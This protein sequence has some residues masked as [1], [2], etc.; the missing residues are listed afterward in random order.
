MGF[1]NNFNQSVQP[2]GT[3]DKSV[4]EQKQKEWGEKLKN[5]GRAVDGLGLEMDE[6]IKEAVVALVSNGLDTVGSCGGHIVE[7]EKTIRLPWVQIAY[8]N[9]PAYRF[10]GEKEIR[11]EIMRKYDLKSERD[12]FLSETEAGKKYYSKTSDCENSPEWE[13]WSQ[14]NEKLRENIS[15]LLDE[16]YK[17]RDSK[18]RLITGRAYPVW[19]ISPDE[20]VLENKNFDEQ[21]EI[22]SETQ[23]EFDLFAKFLK[24]RY[25]KS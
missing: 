11:E 23:K 6:N 2:P 10:V 13:T 22:L 9:E 5:T 18:Y 12:I 24:E 20:K 4:L 16:F 21:K 19:V 14:K 25:F 8:E 7:E 17:D 3:E 1:E 15:T